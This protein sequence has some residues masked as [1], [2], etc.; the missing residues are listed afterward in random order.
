MIKNNIIVTLFSVMILASMVYSCKDTVTYAEKDAD[1][2]EK[3]QAFLDI[4]KI[5]AEPDSGIYFIQEDSL[6]GFGDT[7]KDYDRVYLY[8]NIYSVGDTGSLTWMY[9]TD[10]YQLNPEI[11]IPVYS[12]FNKSAYSS[13]SYTANPG[14]YRG[15]TQMLSE[16]NAEAEIIVP[17]QYG[18]GPDNKSSS[19]GGVSYYGF[20]TL[21]YD[22]KIY[23]V[24]Q[25]TVN[26]AK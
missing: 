23:K 18:L 20:S 14:L 6:K 21:V 13:R 10:Y 17:S 22:L 24:V 25:D 8:M 3:L 5:T 12:T 11:I 1:E 26:V 16:G 9:S 2:Q 4:R 19:S 15:I 7:I